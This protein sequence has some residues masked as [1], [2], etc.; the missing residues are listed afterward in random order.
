MIRIFIPYGSSCTLAQTA[1]WNI[2]PISTN[3][4]SLYRKKN[5]RKYSI[6]ELKTSHFTR[7]ISCC[8]PFHPIDLPKLKQS[9]FVSNKFD[10]ELV[11]YFILYISTEPIVFFTYTSTNRKTQ[12]HV[13]K[14]CISGY[15]ILHMGIKYIELV[16]PI[17]TAHKR[18][19]LATYA[20]HKYVYEYVVCVC[21]CAP[22]DI[23]FFNVP[24]IVEN[25]NWHFYISVVVS[26]FS[27]QFYNFYGSGMGLKTKGNRKE[28]EKETDGFFVRF[29]NKC[30]RRWMGSTVVVGYAPKIEGE[31]ERE[32]K[33][34]RENGICQLP[35]TYGF[36]SYYTYLQRGGH[37]AKQIV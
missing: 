8:R 26:S 25:L 20:I 11:L 32:H 27:I 35:L 3:I 2:L 21:V 34:R 31:K 33:N 14:W 10:A 17:T 1:Q 7:I 23:A 5:G 9:V 29:H 19:N 36:F 16:S 18:A 24:R 12:I 37:K 15:N 4:L 6:F 30:D 22:L 28:S 13:Y